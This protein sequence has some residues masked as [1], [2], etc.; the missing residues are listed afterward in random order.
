MYYLNVAK[1]PTTLGPS[2]R[3]GFGKIGE[4][5]ESLTK[6]YGMELK[7]SI[8]NNCPH[9]DALGEINLLH[10]SWFALQTSVATNAFPGWRISM[11][12][13]KRWSKKCW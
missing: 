6:E 8:P 7:A 4:I 3:T 11:K 5:Q 12:S 13:A 1:D 10:L 9:D 2:G